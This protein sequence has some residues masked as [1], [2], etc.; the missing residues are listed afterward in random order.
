MQAGNQAR[1]DHDQASWETSVSSWI[2]GEAD[3]RPEDLDSPY[4]RQV[5][6][7]YHLIGDVL[8][9]QDLAIKPSD[10]FYARVSKA[11][12]A[13]PSIVAPRNLHGRHPVRLGLSS[14]AVAAAVATVVWVALPYFS[15]PES[16]GPGSVQI[17]A[18]ANEDP[19]LRDYLDAHRE[20]SGSSAVR[21]VSFGSG[22]S[23]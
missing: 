3:I 17:M 18:S 8:R 9:N 1:Q 23:R 11:L 14:L 22:A 6:D 15:G 16:S 2:D 12:D 5:W 13:E 4:G 19:G 20:I 10:F 7:T 21:Q